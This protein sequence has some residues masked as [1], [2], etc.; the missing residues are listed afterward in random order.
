MSLSLIED[1]VVAAHGKW[2]EKRIKSSELMLELAE[3][4]D[5][6]RRHADAS[7]AFKRIAQVMRT[8][9]V[10]LSMKARNRHG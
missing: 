5:E 10:E 1:R 6:L 3:A 2:I 7:D 9:L 4:L 8:A